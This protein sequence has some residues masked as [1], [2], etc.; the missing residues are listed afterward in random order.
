MRWILALAFVAACGSSSLKHAGE[1][2]VASSECDNGLLCDF[3]GH[4]CAN[5]G[6]LDAFTPPPDGGPID[7]SPVDGRPI[8]ARMIDAAIDAAPDAPPDA[9]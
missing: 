4:V 6:S 8:D 2:C 5:T 9:P 7:A 3:G 1:S